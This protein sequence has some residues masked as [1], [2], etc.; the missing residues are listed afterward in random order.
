MVMKYFL[1]FLPFLLFGALHAQPV[2]HPSIGLVSEP[3][4][5]DSICYIPWYLGSFSSSGISAGDTAADFRLYSIN[6]DSIQ[7]ADWL[8][9]GKPV[10]LIAGSYTCPV[11]RNKIPAI[12]S[13]VSQYSGQILVAVIYTVEAHPDV[14]TS[15]YFGYVNTGSQNINAG[16]LYRQP[17]TYGERKAVASDMLTSLT[18]NAPVFLDGPC[19]NWWLHYGPAPNNAYLIDTT[20]MVFSKHAWFDKYPDNMI[21]DI[22]SLLGNPVTCT[23]A[24]NQGTYSFQLLSNDTVSGAPGTTISLE[25]ELVNSGSQDALVE[26]TRVINNMPNGWASSLCLDACYPTGTDSVTILVPSGTTQHFT[27]YIYTGLTEDTARARVRFRN[28]NLSGNQYQVNLFGITSSAVGIQN[29]S[30]DPAGFDCF[31]NPSTGIFQLRISPIDGSS[32]I[33]ELCDMSGKIITTL[34]AGLPAGTGE[35]I[36]ADF[37]DAAPG[38]YLMRIRSGNALKGILPVYI[39]R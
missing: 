27:F 8:L 14:D 33:L 17:V 18:I 9:C 10:L 20:G 15:V 34:N 23:G 6:G 12:N 36:Q 4:D 29:E 16:I 26:V 39:V 22:D 7:L 28:V 21:C 38:S 37:R 2:L 5:A 13:L 3:D 30:L 32:L 25:G 1:L 11:F 31:P 19:N 35:I 24:G